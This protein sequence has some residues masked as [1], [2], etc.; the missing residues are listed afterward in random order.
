VREARRDLEQMLDLARPGS[1]R[2]EIVETTATGGDGIGDLWRAVAAHRDYLV[3]SGQLAVRRT[4]RVAQELRRVL[5]ARTEFK[6][7][8]LV[9]GEE[10]STAVKALAAGELDPYQAAE[11][12]LAK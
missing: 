1:W 3:G 10:F 2:P 4:D 5:L 9:A 6:V 7:D 8:E 12:L 11:S